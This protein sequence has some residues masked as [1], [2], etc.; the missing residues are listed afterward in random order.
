M[1][2]S[3]LP[4]AYKQCIILFPFSTQRTSVYNQTSF[5]LD[6]SS[7]MELLNTS[8]TAIEY[9]GL[10]IEFTR[11][12]VPCDNKTLLLLRQNK[13]E[14]K[15][16]CGK[17]EEYLLEER[18]FYFK[19]QNNSSIEIN[20]SPIFRLTYKLVDYCYNV[21]L[22]GKNN[23]IFLQ[24]IQANLDCNFRVHLPY[25]NRVALSI[26]TNLPS[27]Y[28]THKQG[29]GKTFNASD[30]Y[31]SIA[32]QEQI[33]LSDF[34]NFNHMKCQGGDLRIELIDH[35][36]NKNWVTCLSSKHPPKLHFY[37]SSDNVLAIHITKTL[38][39]LIKTNSTTNNRTSDTLHHSQITQ[40]TPS[41]YFEYNAISIESISSP[42][43]AFGWI[44]LNQQSCVTVIDQAPK[45]WH[46]ASE[47]CSKHNAKL[48][49]IQNEKEQ[50]V[51]DQ[52]ILKR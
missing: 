12:N 36:A 45:S 37:K 29:I 13:N 41:L 49:S 32:E 15:R 17:L 40:S 31:K 3:I 14:V 1:D 16:M 22:S 48:A 43:C 20:G 52:L 30:G 28:L 46:E 33:E 25:G 10:L 5:V 2:D 50:L 21:T 11:L 51:I 35:Q 38:L 26:V 6:A 39:N 23:S 8:T 18:T 42:K 24:P 47:E 4:A 9:S 19:K 7:N 44:S 27:V 34:K